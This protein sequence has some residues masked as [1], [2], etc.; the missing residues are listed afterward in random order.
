MK[1][2]RAY[3]GNWKVDLVQS[4]QKITSH[5]ARARPRRVA[6]RARHIDCTS[7]LFAFRI[8]RQKEKWYEHARA[9]TFWRNCR[10]ARERENENKYSNRNSCSTLLLLC[11]WAAGGCWYTI[12]AQFRLIKIDARGFWCCRSN[13]F[14]FHLPRRNGIPNICTSLNWAD[15]CSLK[16]DLF[17]RRFG[18][19]RIYFIRELRQRHFPVRKCTSQYFPPFRWLFGCSQRKG[20]CHPHPHSTVECSVNWVS[21]HFSIFVVCSLCAQMRAAS[22]L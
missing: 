8:L 22:S 2:K 7:I 5:N 10:I 1:K 21:L 6:P 14:R 11:M 16:M 19:I 17:F 13:L 18:T 15:P 12:H 9:A 4:T 20:F 3:S